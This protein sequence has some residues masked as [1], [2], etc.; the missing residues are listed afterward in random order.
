MT[1]PGKP[2]EN[3]FGLPVPWWAAIAAVPAFASVFQTGTIFEV[4]GEVVT[5]AIVGD[6][7]SM[8]WPNGAAIVMLL[9]GIFLTPWLRIKIGKRAIY[10]AGLV[11]FIVGNGFEGTSTGIPQMTLGQG[12]SG[13]GKGLVLAN[14]RA[15]LFQS[16]KD[17]LR[18]AIAFYGL[19]GYASRCFSPVAAAY[20][21]DYLSWR[22]VY[23]ANI[24]LGFVGLGLTYRFLKNDWPTTPNRQPLDL[25]GLLLLVGSMIG[26]IIFFDRG[27]RWGWFTSNREVAVLLLTLFLFAGF[28]WRQ[29]A[30]EYPLMELRRIG[31]IRTYV[32]AQFSKSIFLVTLYAVLE[33]ISEYMVNLRG[34]PRT[35][36]GWV[37]VPAGL[38]MAATMYWSAYHT[39]PHS[40]RLRLM[41]GMLSSA[42]TTWQLSAIDLYTSKF[43]IAGMLLLWGASLGLTVL[44]VLA[45]AQFGLDPKA[46]PTASGIGLTVL[47]LPIVLVHA[48]V[49]TAMT[50]WTDTYTDSLSLALE[51]GR[52]VVQD[53]REQVSDSLEYKT[54]PGGALRERVQIVLADWQTANAEFC[55][56]QTVLR[57]VALVPLVGLIIAPW[58]DPRRVT[59]TEDYRMPA[60]ALL[61][62]QPE[63]S[64]A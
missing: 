18:K 14:L 64:P 41:A 35:T 9:L 51:H 33:L 36:S 25:E 37:I 7:Y 30:A 42:M 52:A 19:V 4:S 55:A 61:H 28:L 47:I 43:W 62:P 16:L 44:P 6:R 8:Q 32:L 38:G 56:Y 27:Q 48:V 11:L 40:R 46:A 26:L 17:S 22:W 45:Y 23:G 57:F 2:D 59:E 60:P 3:I 15:M 39:S 20:A 49:S 34:Y 5:D 58:I 24:V 50:R 12:I 53:V 54:G 29:F 1:E 10:V 31:L 13:L 21:V 63:P